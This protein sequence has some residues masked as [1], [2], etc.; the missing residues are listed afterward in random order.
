MAGNASVGSP[1]VQT[2]IL[3]GMAAGATHLKVPRLGTPD[4]RHMLVLVVALQGM[5]AGGVAVH[6][7]GMGE[8]L[9]D[10]VE[11]HP[12]AFGR[13]RDGCEISRTF[14]RAVRGQLIGMRG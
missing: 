7:A 1:L 11:N 8:H 5:V 3:S 6:A 14:Q 9:P 12:R 13:V 2:D 4:G 10:L